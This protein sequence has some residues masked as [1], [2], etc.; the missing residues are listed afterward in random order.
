MSNA[1]TAQLIAEASLDL[2]DEVKGLFN[3]VNKE[4]LQLRADVEQLQQAI[5]PM[6]TDIER[7]RAELDRFTRERGNPR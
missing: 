6:A 7:V 2:I 4:L 1:K 5:A 3:L